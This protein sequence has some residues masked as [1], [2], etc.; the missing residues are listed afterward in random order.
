MFINKDE[1]VSKVLQRLYAIGFWILLA[2]TSVYVLIMSVVV[3]APY[4]KYVAGLF[5]LGGIIMYL[6]ITPILA[7]LIEKDV[8]P[9]RTVLL[10]S[11]VCGLVVGILVT[12]N[13]MMNYSEFYKNEHVYMLIP[14]FLISTISAIVISLVIIVPIVR[15]NNWRQDEIERKLD[16]SE[17]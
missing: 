12:I 14:I 4:E 11:A 9:F 13:N 17:L 6:T 10:S 7:G 8:T 15:F 16:E 5:L 1:R 3:N 2:I